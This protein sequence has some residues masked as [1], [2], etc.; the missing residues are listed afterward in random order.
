LAIA[1]AFWAPI[2]K[3]KFHLH[4]QIQ[5]MLKALRL[6]L[7]IALVLI[8]FDCKQSHAQSLQTR[9]QFTTADGLPSNHIYGAVQDSLGFLWIA[10]DNG[11]SRYDGKNF[12][13]YGI[14]HGLSGIDVL[15]VM[16]DNAGQ[17]WVNCYRHKPCIYNATKDSFEVLDSNPIDATKFNSLTKFQFLG[18]DSVVVLAYNYL[19]FYKGKKMLGYRKRDM[20]KLLEHDGVQFPLKL[21]NV[22]KNYNVWLTNNE[23]RLQIFSGPEPMENAFLIN[24]RI[25]AIG[26]S[27][28]FYELLFNK[29][30]EYNFEYLFKASTRVLHT[31]VLS[32]EVH[33]I[34][35][36]KSVYS[37]QIQG[38]NYGSLL[39][40]EYSVL[41][42]Q[43]D[44]KGALWLGTENDGLLCYDSVRIRN[45][46]GLNHLAQNH[47]CKIKHLPSGGAIVGHSSATYATYKESFFNTYPK[48]GTIPSKSRNEVKFI[49]EYQQKP[50]VVTTQDLCYNGLTKPMKYNDNE[51]LL[52]QST[53]C[54][55]M[56]QNGRLAIGGVGG[57]GIY[58]IASRAFEYFNKAHF[59]CVDM[60]F[61]STQQRLYFISAL[62][63][64]YLNMQESSFTKVNFPLANAN[65]LA[66]HIVAGKANEIIITTSH[67]HVY[68]LQNEKVV[69]KFMLQQGQP[70]SIRCVDVDAYGDIYFGTAS[71]LYMLVRNGSNNKF[72]R[73]KHIGT[74]DGI[75]H[76]VINDIDI[77]GDS[78][79]LATD[80]GISIVPR[81]FET[82][83]INARVK[84][85]SMRANNKVLALQNHYA[86]GSSENALSLEFV[87]VDITQ[88]LQALEYALSDTTQWQQLNG[89]ILN[90]QLPSG[91]HQIFVRAKDVNGNICS[92][93]LRLGIEIATPF[94]KTWWFL[95]TA[96]ILLTSAIA[97]LMSR[98]KVA[99]LKRRLAEQ[100][101]IKE[102]RMRI[103]ADLHDDMGATLSS[104]SINSSM[105]PKLIEQNP[106]L[107]KKVSNRMFKQ[108]KQ[109]SDN[110]G[111]IVWSL[112]EDKQQLMN[113]STRI[114]TYMHDI[115]GNTNVNYKVDIDT[116]VNNAIKGLVM[117]KNLLLICKEGINNAAKY[118][119][120][121]MLQVKA[122][123]KEESLLVVIQ[124]D[125][126]GYDTQVAG[127]NGLN[128][129]KHRSAE[130]NAKL[131]IQSAVNKGTIISL[132]IPIAP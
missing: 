123:I 110:L 55:T 79:Y 33:L 118:S 113:F 71:G 42:A 116:E 65:E 124:D 5:M 73:V 85:T 12:K 22:E 70:T 101:L 77:F 29:Q 54:C 106:E 97:Y 11:V 107:A 98:R 31:A 8:K 103:S 60:V 131:S 72:N 129:I 76:N 95:L 117:R 9:F 7:L 105:M 46:I 69:A 62:G 119:S 38:T 19:L 57:L 21:C 87:G 126:I 111:D 84:L 35:K 91:L 56:L 68:I 47:C 96:A 37:Y 15:Q 24:N 121:K 50:L 23:N 40:T 75:A 102:E 49:A 92:S 80:N 82:P 81:I 20:L 86:L 59:R 112:N 61:D 127:G 66:T 10:T 90:L 13:N 18:D 41:G 6:S 100:A 28:S 67:G 104:F 32:D 74:Q 128:N 130:I 3:M 25:F 51:Q 78:I 108:S 2:T 26:R 36:N 114:T 115:L 43:Y 58:N 45:V 1:I 44:S 125:G 4:K 34:T 94:Y 27:G 122:S 39:N 48:I 132:E 93:T 64:Y 109:I 120:A 83:V 16:L 53:K 89:G 17:L 14:Q 52:V 30:N 63:V 99:A 88:H